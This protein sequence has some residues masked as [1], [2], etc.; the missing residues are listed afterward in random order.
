MNQVA[1]RNVAPKLNLPKIFTGV[2]SEYESFVLQLVLIFNSDLSRYL[3]NQPNLRISDT[4]S[5]LA[6]PA[7]ESFRPHIDETSSIIDFDT[8]E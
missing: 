3:L 8:W 7:M 2:L 1:T 5:F 6:G 4:A